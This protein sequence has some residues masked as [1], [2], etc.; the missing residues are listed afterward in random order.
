[1]RRI[2]LTLALLGALLAST[3]RAETITEVLE[4][5]QLSRLDGRVAAPADSERAA[6]VRASFAR[7]VA[8]APPAHPVELRVMQGGVQAE[9]ML[10]RLL[11]V[12]EAVGDLPEGERLMLL[13]HEYGH[14]VL[15]HWDRLVGLYRHHIPGEVRPDT[16]NPGAQALGRDGAELSHRQEFEADAFG[17]RLAQQ[18]GVG[19][20]EALSL[21]M[22][23]PAAS[24]T[25][26]HPAT[27]RR[28]AQLRTL[29]STPCSPSPTGEP[30]RIEAASARPR[31]TRLSGAS[32]YSTFSG[33]IFSSARSGE[34]GPSGNHGRAAAVHSAWMRSRSST[35]SA[36]PAIDTKVE[37]TS[38]LK[39][40]LT[41]CGRASAWRRQK[42]HSRPWASNSSSVIGRLSSSSPVPGSVSIAKRSLPI[43]SASWRCAASG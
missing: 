13:S 29:P 11:V 28:I 23:R 24:D 8:L 19:L 25:P 6:R 33:T 2:T 37:C 27:R 35:C 14:L 4:R 43:R 31:T 38:S 26:T 22:R 34:S 30:L 5:S 10:G 16:T 21:L 1:M 7:L 42:N 20:D 17:F 41:G 15:G 12:G 36:R 39:A 40:R 32:Q 18:L 3:A 9:A